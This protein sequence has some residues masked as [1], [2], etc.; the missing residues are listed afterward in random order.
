MAKYAANCFKI[1]GYSTG[2]TAKSRRHAILGR[3]GL[4]LFSLN[5][6]FCMKRK[7]PASTTALKQAVYQP[8]S[9]LT[10]QA[11]ELFAQ[12]NCQEVLNLLAYA[13]PRQA[14]DAAFLNIAAACEISVGVS[15]RAEAYLRRAL[16]L[17][18]NFADAWHNLGNL[19][20]D[21]RRLQEAGACFRQAL[22]L[23]PGFADAYADQ[24]QLLA[25]QGLEAEAEKNY[26]RALSLKPDCAAA[27]LSLA[28][29]LLS[30][31][32]WREGLRRY[33]ARCALPGFT[34]LNAALAHLPFPKWQGQDLQGKSIVLWPEQSYG[35]QIQ[36]CRYAAVL[37]RLGA[38]KIT[39]VCDAA[40]TGLFKSLA[41]VDMVIAKTDTAR[42]AGHDYWSPLLSLPLHC[43]TTLDNLPAELPYLQPRPRELARWARKLPA[44]GLRV[45]LAW[46]DA[47][48][49]SQDR[50][51]S[52]PDLPSLA[53][54][55][56]VPGVVFI[57]LQPGSGSAAPPTAQ[58]LLALGEQRRD[59]A[60][61]AA[62]VAQLDLLICVD[63]AVAHLAGALGTPCWLLLQKPAT[64]SLWLRGRS[65]SPWYPGVMRLFRQPVAGDWGPVIAEAAQALP[66]WSRTASTAKR[67]KPPAWAGR[68]RAWL[69]V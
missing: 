24:G 61:T 15:A 36:F 18:P 31:G 49:H 20:R 25:L 48:E 40:L 41:A 4:Q 27:E 30:Q 64:D 17:A 67:Q 10:Q 23:R 45:G 35:A 1:R 37:K 56:D 68:F 32:H 3:D 19:L 5:V 33:E 46:Q 53:A 21:S 65:D 66:A 28:I 14:D 57:S 62:I 6:I 9:A 16:E 7:S 54:L 51:R 34:L 47:G 43:A 59:F 39:L 55:W 63:T 29:L 58:P 13:D 38:A 60:A 42:L 26:R 22:S 69:G 2:S 12:G 8:P 44:Q 50:F 11:L 52:L